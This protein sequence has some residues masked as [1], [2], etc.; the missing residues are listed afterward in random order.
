[1]TVADTG[2]GTG[3]F[4]LALARM[5]GPDG[6]VFAVDVQAGALAKLEEKAEKLGL[7][8]VIETWKCKADDIGRLPTVDFALSFYM[9]HETPDIDAYFARMVECIRPGGKMLLVEPRFHVS[10]SHFKEELAAAARAGFT[11]AGTPAVLG[12]LAALLARG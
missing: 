1:M 5:V 11:P 12:S 4:S 7:G 8:S 9:A 10:R 6:R 2:C 3:F